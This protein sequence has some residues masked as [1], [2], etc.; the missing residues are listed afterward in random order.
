[1]A[2][3]SK[4]SFIELVLTGAAAVLDAHIGLGAESKA[5]KPLDELGPRVTAGGCCITGL[6]LATGAGLKKSPPALA[7]D[8]CT[9]AGVDFWLYDPRLPNAA[10]LACGDC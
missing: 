3:K 1:M 4:R 8:V 10:G 7:I 2:E 5:P 9:A 6:V